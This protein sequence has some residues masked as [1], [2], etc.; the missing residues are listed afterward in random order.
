[1]RGDE[2][3]STGKLS[4]GTTGSTGQE[5]LC[6][7]CGGGGTR[8]QSWDTTLVQ[9]QR[10][11]RAGGSHVSSNCHWTFFDES[12]ICVGACV[13]NSATPGCQSWYACPAWVASWKASFLLNVGRSTGYLPNVKTRLRTPLLAMSP[14]ATARRLGRK[15]FEWH[16]A[17]GIG[18]HAVNPKLMYR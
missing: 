3:G 11:S 7:R 2:P 8:F 17:P 16:F 9:S 13:C 12:K 4:W 5:V 6:T 10:G 15:S 1:M 14:E 18:E